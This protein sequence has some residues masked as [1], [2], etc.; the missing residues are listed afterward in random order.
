M[1][2]KRLFTVIFIII[3]SLIGGK[4]TL[5]QAGAEVGVFETYVVSPN[6]R[7]EVP[8]RIRNV[9]DLY[10]IDLEMQFDPSILSVEDADPAASGVQPALGEFLDAGLLLY[11][12]VDLEEGIVR[13]A[14]SQVNPS[15]PKSGDGII[16]VV[17]FQGKAAG[18][19]E[20]RITN[21]TLSDR[22]GVEIASS[23]VN[24]IVSVETDAPIVEAT[25]IPV[26]NPTGMII[27]PTMGPTPTPTVTPNVT[28]TPMPTA[29]PR[30]V[31]EEQ[32]ASNTT[33]LMDATETI[34]PEDKEEPFFQQYWWVL[35]VVILLAVAVAVYLLVI[36]KK[37][38][39]NTEY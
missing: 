37:R 27:V 28:A 16:L 8:I 25:S 9:Q 21:S 38:G 14:M 39:Q 34:A 4:L 18:E 3:I 5:A 20:L 19:T 29:T 15:E 2:Q 30:S 6:G 33:G 1:M 22:E 24:S 13:F 35:L 26:Q 17:Y 32:A 31:V 7:I 11:N 10:A 12:Y 23:G 36:R